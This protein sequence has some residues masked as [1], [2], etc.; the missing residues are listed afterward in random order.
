MSRALVT[1]YLDF[2]AIGIHV[3]SLRLG[4]VNMYILFLFI[5]IHTYNASLKSTDSYQQHCPTKRKL[6]TKIF[7]KTLESFYSLWKSS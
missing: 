3:A 7:H 5:S 6:E 4:H 2:N 1:V